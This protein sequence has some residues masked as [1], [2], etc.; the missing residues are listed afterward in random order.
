[1]PADGSLEAD[2]SP[3]NG[4]HINGSNV[5]TA[6]PPMVRIEAFASTLIP[7]PEDALDDTEQERARLTAELAAA[8]ERLAAA[9]QRTV[10]RELATRVA[11]DD[12]V[13]AARDRLATMQRDH[14]SV[15]A[16]IR[17]VAAAEVERIR[18]AAHEQLATADGGD[19]AGA[20]G[21]A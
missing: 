17:G 18:R 13:A 2:M 19:E 12:V 8:H 11:L 6:A 5:E 15:L 16:D 4:V 10:D 9:K 3:L 7:C 1:V 14:E 21:A 20:S